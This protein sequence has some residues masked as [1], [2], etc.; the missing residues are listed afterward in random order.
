[1]HDSLKGKLFKKHCL[2]LFRVASSDV[3]MRPKSGR[4]G[5]MVDLE[6]KF[7]NSLINQ[8]NRFN[9]HGFVVQTCNSIKPQGSVYHKIKVNELPDGA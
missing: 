1:M 6:V 5:N 8:S 2:I 9:V 7:S 4:L 3:G